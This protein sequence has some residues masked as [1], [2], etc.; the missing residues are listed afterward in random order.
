MPLASNTI[1][2]DRLRFYIKLLVYSTIA[3]SL[4]FLDLKQH[5]FAPV[6]EKLS[7]LEVVV[8][9]SFRPLKDWL[10]DF[11]SHFAS[12]VEL[13][14]ENEE[15][16]NAQI[17]SE[18]R[19]QKLASIERRL[20]ELQSLLKLRNQ[21]PNGMHAVTVIAASN[22]PYDQWLRVQFTREAPIKP[23]DYLVETKGLVGQVISVEDAQAFVRLVSDQRASVHVQVLRTGFRA[24]L[25]GRGKYN[26]LELKFVPEEVDIK[27]DDILVTTGMGGRHPYGIPVGKVISV[28]PD[29]TSTFSRIIVQSLASP[30]STNSFIALTGPIG[31]DLYPLDK[32]K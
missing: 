12:N 25:F 17:Y 13:V 27:V 10:E 15:L 32:S 11:S 18:V 16:K 30:S 7:S 9:E 6:K 21:S 22:S 29:R 3:L 31:D 24:V 5:T 26:S 20:E 28:D 23:G 14:R 1:K 8:N 4:V 2:G 19:L